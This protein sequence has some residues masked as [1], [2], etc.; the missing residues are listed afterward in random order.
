MPSIFRSFIALVCLF[1]STQVFAQLA[2]TVPN[3]DD[4]AMIQVGAGSG[5]DSKDPNAVR[6]VIRVDG[7][8]LLPMDGRKTCEG[9]CGYYVIATLKSTVDANGKDVSYVDIQL[10]A[11]G[12]GQF[13]SSTEDGHLVHQGDSNFYFQASALRLDYK[14]DFNLD[15]DHMLRFSIIG[16]SMGGAIKATDDLTVFAN[17]ALDIAAFSV[18][19]RISDGTTIQGAGGGHAQGEVG[20]QFRDRFRLSFGAEVDIVRK[21]IAENHYDAGYKT[22]TTHHTGHFTTHECHEVWNTDVYDRRAKYG[23]LFIDIDA[24][25]TKSISAFGC[26]EYAFYR[27]NED[28]VP[29]GVTS[30]PTGTPITPSSS[31]GWEFKI[32][33]IYR[34]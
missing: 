20:I 23:D 5:I 22:C 28:A 3:P 14:R 30:P 25:I 8:Y 9:D 13:S 16:L 34:F 7:G 4:D 21:K 24:A 10:D 18:A 26:A 15:L 6:V 11:A 27:M 1:S 19:Q 32:G 2:D 31:A 33:I 29:S 12:I 17:A